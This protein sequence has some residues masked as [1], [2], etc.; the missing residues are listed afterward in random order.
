LSVQSHMG[1]YSLCEFHLGTGEN[2]G[3]GR[4]KNMG[5]PN[6]NEGGQVKGDKGG[7]CLKAREK[8]TEYRARDQSSGWSG[9]L[10]GSV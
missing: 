2:V 7:L 10:G 5:P 1:G 4:V 3:P 9:P 6:G 8:N